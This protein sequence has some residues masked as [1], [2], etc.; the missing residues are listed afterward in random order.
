M[1]GH[2]GRHLINPRT[3]KLGIQTTG[4]LNPCEHCA[5]GKIIQA[6]ITKVSKSQQAKNPGERIFIDISSIMYPSAGG[7]KY[8]LLIV[9]EATDYTH[10]FFLKKKSD[11]IEIILIWIR[12]LFKRYHIRIKKIRLDNSGENR[13]LQANLINKI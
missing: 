1:M 4:K 11:M 2:T 9:D 3:K 5:R 13:M 12:N 10:S 6:N 8:W 7:K